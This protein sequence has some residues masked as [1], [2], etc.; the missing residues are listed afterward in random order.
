M[1]AP[2][3]GAANCLA[4]VAI[5][6][7]GAVASAPRTVAVR[8]EICRRGETLRV[9]LS[10]DASGEEIALA[11]TGLTLGIDRA[12]ARVSV[13]HAGD[14]RDAQGTLG[15][16]IATR[17]G[18]DRVRPAWPARVSSTVGLSDAFARAGVCDLRRRAASGD[19]GMPRV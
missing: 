5:H 9:S 10:C 1:S 18:R 3:P 14:L 17:Q 8:S 2:R 7:P 6:R 11:S 4:P 15:T 19:H 13:R 12:G 16:A